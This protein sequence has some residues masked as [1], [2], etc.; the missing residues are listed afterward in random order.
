MING[1]KWGQQSFIVLYTSQCYCGPTIERRATSRN[2]PGAIRGAFCYQFRW[3]LGMS[4]MENSL[5]VTI[6]AESLAGS[7]PMSDLAEFLALRG[8]IEDVWDIADSDFDQG[9]RA[10]AFRTSASFCCCRRS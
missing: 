8:H 4:S 3:W 10:M 6:E 7:T 2:P 9:A 5:T 1:N